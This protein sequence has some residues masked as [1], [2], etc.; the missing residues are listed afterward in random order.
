[1]DFYQMVWVQ[2]FYM[3]FSMD[4]SNVGL[5]RVR[6]GEDL[7]IKIFFFVSDGKQNKLECFFTGKFFKGWPNILE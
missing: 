4:R 2:Y 3:N 6:V 5:Q 1:M 7:C